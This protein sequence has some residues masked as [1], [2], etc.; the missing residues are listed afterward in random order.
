MHLISA[1]KFFPSWSLTASTSF[2]L[3]HLACLSVVPHN[4]S[5]SSVR[6]QTKRRKGRHCLSFQAKPLSPSMALHSEQSL[7]LETTTRMS[8]YWKNRIRCQLWDNR[9][10]KNQLAPN[11]NTSQ[12][13]SGF[14][15]LTRYACTQGIGPA[16][17]VSYEECFVS[18][19]SLL[20]SIQFL[21]H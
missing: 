17:T 3:L 8:W 14:R 19:L 12:V 11:G 20:N 18:S 6:P 9:A 7:F 13:F 4:P 10:F 1:L 15:Q 16:A 21:A 2:P 5:D